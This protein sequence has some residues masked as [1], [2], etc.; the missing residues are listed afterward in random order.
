MTLKDGLRVRIRLTYTGHLS[1]G[2]RPGDWAIVSKVGTRDTVDAFRFDFGDGIKRS[3]GR[4]DLD[5]LLEIL[6]LEE[7]PLENI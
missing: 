6:P 7:L 4:H 1:G 5:E 2:L 3:N